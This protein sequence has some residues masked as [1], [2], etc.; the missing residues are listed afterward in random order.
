MGYRTVVLA[1]LVFTAGAA[2]AQSASNPASA[3]SPQSQP[4]PAGAPSGNSPASPGVNPA[5]APVAPQSNAGA[6]ERGLTQPRSANAPVAGPA[7]TPAPNGVTQRVHNAATHDVDAQG[8]T[9]DAHGKPVGQAP[10][11]RPVVEPSR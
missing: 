4:L 5:S 2:F 7:T 1:S 11:P 8:H 3:P 6:T 10:V 9:L